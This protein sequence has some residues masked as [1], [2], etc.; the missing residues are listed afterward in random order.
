MSHYTRTM[1]SMNYV[2]RQL[3][4]LWQELDADCEPISHDE[5]TIP[6]IALYT[7]FI[8]LVLRSIAVE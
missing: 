4:T 2:V 6:A 5:P 7:T 1:F 8:Y 3:K